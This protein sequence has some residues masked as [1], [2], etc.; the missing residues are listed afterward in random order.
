[1]VSEETLKSILLKGRRLNSERYYKHCRTNHV[2]TFYFFCLK[3]SSGTGNAALSSTELNE[4]IIEE[5]KQRRVVVNENFN[6]QGWFGQ[7]WTDW[8]DTSKNEKHFQYEYCEVLTRT[9]E[10][11]YFYQ[12]NP[13]YVAV[14][15]RIF[16]EFE[17][18][19]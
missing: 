2:K 8:N 5:L 11:P 17:G 4:Y 9:G 15:K 18:Q 7:A 10:N 3:L 1:M 19:A 12:I 16:D 13:K 14:V 6:P